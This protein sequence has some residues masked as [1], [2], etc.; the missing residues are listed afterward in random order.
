MKMEITSVWV[1]VWVRQRHIKTTRTNAFGEG[2]YA[3]WCAILQGHGETGW[4]VAKDM[5]EYCN[6]YL[7]FLIYSIYLKEFKL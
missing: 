1:W 6:F 3:E 5:D 4:I 2:E 7:N